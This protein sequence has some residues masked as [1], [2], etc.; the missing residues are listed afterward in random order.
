MNYSQLL[1]SVA[2]QF[3]SWRTSCNKGQNTPASLREQAVALKS[4]YPV[5][6][7]VTALGINHTALNRWSVSNDTSKQP[8]FISLP[9]LLPE[10]KTVRPLSFTS[11]EFPNGIVLKLTEEQLNSG[12]LSKIYNLKSGGND[13]SAI[14]Q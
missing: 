8:T 1:E 10:T 5:G 11:C 9:A 13:D 14:G 4:H 2:K 7:I 12:L 3:A 6:K